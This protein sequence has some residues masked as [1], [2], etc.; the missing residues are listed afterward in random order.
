MGV[1][2]AMSCEEF[3]LSMETPSLAIWLGTPSKLSPRPF[4][5]PVRS[6]CPSGV[7]GVTP[8]GF[9]GALLVRGTCENSWARIAAGRRHKPATAAMILGYPDKRIQTFLSAQLPLGSVLNLYTRPSAIFN[10]WRRPLFE[11]SLAGR[12]VTVTSSP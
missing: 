12:A 5:T 1:P 8:D 2:V 9:G 3:S 7:R 4:H 10:S 11:S 6:G